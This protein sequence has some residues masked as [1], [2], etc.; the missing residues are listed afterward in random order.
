MR[1]RY[2]I[3]LPLVMF[4]LITGSVLTARPATAEE[5][6]HFINHSDAAVMIEIR[7]STGMLDQTL[8]LERNHSESSHFAQKISKVSFRFDVSYPCYYSSTPP[9]KIEGFYPPETT[10]TIRG[11]KGNYSVT[12]HH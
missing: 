10:Y 4:G 12:V 1:L 3:L 5:T 8:C 7:K 6:A 9:S 11:R 2:A